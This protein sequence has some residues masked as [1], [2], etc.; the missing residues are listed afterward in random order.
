MCYA[1]FPTPKKWQGA[2]VLDQVKAIKRNSNYEVLVFK[3]CTINEKQED[4]IIDDIKV[5]TIKPLLMPSYILNGA[6]EGI[7]A[8]MF[9]KTLCKLNIPLKQIAFVHCHTTN[10]A[11]FGFGVKQRNNKTKVLVQFH[12]LDPL[13]LRNGK[14][15]EKRWNRRY[16]ARKSINTLNRADLLICISEPVRDALLAFPYP[17]KGEIYP[18]ALNMLSMVKDMPHITPQKI[19]ILNNGV[20]TSIFHLIEKN[21]HKETTQNPIETRRNHTSFRIGCIANFQELKDHRT[22]VEAFNLLIKRGHKN[23]SLS[24]LGSGETRSEIEEFL[25]KNSIYNFVEWPKEMYHENLPQYYHSLDLFVLPSYYEG[26]G[27]VCTEAAACGVP[28]MICTNQGAAE[29]IPQN[30]AHLWTFEPKNYIQLADRIDYYIKY[31]PKQHL[32][33]TYDIDI[34]IKEFLN[35]L[36]TL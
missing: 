7:I 22:L 15:A 32:C 11:A 5:H 34:L 31:R 6:T 33:K 12:D 25:Q 16:R 36:K 35:F 27:C 30:E 1:I 20:D 10:H 8:K 28:Y 21:E 4:Y 13:T 26:F 14:W 9:V 2:Y 29:Y 3:T 17:R 18:H 23:L 24:L 19:Y